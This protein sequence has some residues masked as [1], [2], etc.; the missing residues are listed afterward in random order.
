MNVRSFQ[1]WAL[2][3]SALVLIYTFVETNFLGG[4]G[5][6]NSESYAIR[7]IITSVVFAV[8]LPAIYSTQPQIGR[9]GKVGLFLMIVPPAA[10]IGW[11][12]GYFID[13]LSVPGVLLALP[14]LLLTN[15]LSISWLLFYLGYFI[16]G[17]LTTQARVFPKWT[18]WLFMFYSILNIADFFVWRIL[19]EGPL[20]LSV[21]AVI[22]LVEAAAL[23][24]YGWQIVR[25][26]KIPAGIAYG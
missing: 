16:V 25:H 13:P 12:L 19:P 2:I 4:S 23:V 5:D 21:Y 26:Q 20:A 11:F 9:W 3:V 7:G 17:W 10:T 1:G 15:A 6:P 24:G 22:T 18:G 14:Y 8:G